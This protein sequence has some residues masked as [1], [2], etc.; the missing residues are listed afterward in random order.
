MN[1]QGRD[2]QLSLN[3]NDVQLLHTELA[4]MAL[5]VPDDER[6]RAFFGQGTHNAV[7]RFQQEHQLAPTG[8]VDAATARAINQA[9]DASFYTVVGTVVSPDRA[10]VGGLRV[11]IVDKNIGQDVPLT[12]TTT[13][14]RGRYTARFA[15]SS[16][17]ARGKAQP[18][19]QAR[20]YAGQT[21][22][23]GSAVCYN[24]TNSE[25]LNV[26]L[27]A[28]A[29]AL[30]SEYE[31]L[32][33]ALAA[34]YSGRFGDLKESDDQ[35]DITYLANKTGWDARAVALA[36]L[37]DQFSQQTPSRTGAPSINPAFYY[38]LFGYPLK[39][40]H[41]MSQWFQASK[42]VASSDGHPGRF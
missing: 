9:V 34:H 15:A 11:Q 26:T 28:N 17:Q 24:A 10:G 39:A 25:T 35:Q 1:L 32:T 27:P 33:G 18:D 42:V 40:G 5:P 29:P 21:F 7:V 20:V 41:Q 31:T 13:D 23:A 38:A 6:Q 36:A 8:I 30:P 4:Q 37:A 12:E 22:L 16:L 3:G 19:L 14:E 2:L